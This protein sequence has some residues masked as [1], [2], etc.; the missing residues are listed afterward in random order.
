M[1]RQLS[2]L[3]CLYFLGIAVPVSAQDSL[4]VETLG[5]KT[6]SFTMVEGEMVGE[7]ADF[8]KKAISEAQFT[9][10]GDYPD[11][12]SCSA[13]THALLPL[14]DEAEYKTMALGVGVPTTRWLHSIAQ[15]PSTAV[16]QIKEFNTIHALS[17]NQRTVLPIPDMKSVEDAR[18]IQRAGSLHWSIIGFGNE[19]WNN[20]PWL[21]DQ[22]YNGLPK[23]SQKEHYPHYADCKAFLDQLYRS[24]NGDLSVF[25]AAVKNSSVLQAF[26]RTIEAESSDGRALAEAFRASVE[27]CRM[28]AHKLYFEKNRFRVDEEKRLLRQELKHIGFDLEQDRLFLKWDLNF[29]S[30][31]FQPYAFYGLGNTL[32]EIAEFN[33]NRSLHIGVIPRYQQKK[34]RVLDLTEAENTR[35]KRLA[36]LIKAGKKDSWTVIDLRQMIQESYYAP[37]RYLL[38]EPVWDLIKRHD[39]VVI[40]ALEQETLLNYTK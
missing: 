3:L 17:E 36:P 7:G 23:A 32:S 5:P 14:L 38:S 29:L 34:G 16:A 4:S 19:S 39:I 8:L 31:G 35:S 30:R 40:P 10:L 33:G 9:L 1:I 11:S 2:F 26:L 25:A 21:L 37:M 18:F 27:L 15:K 13:F 22:M 28:H 6:Y 20:L 24:R 12:K